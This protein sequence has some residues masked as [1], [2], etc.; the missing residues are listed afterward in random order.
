MYILGDR[1]QPLA[2]GANG[3]ASRTAAAPDA[4]IGEAGSDANA[5]VDGSPGTGRTPDPS[6]ATAYLMNPGHTGAGTDST[7]KPPLSRRWMVFL[8]APVSYPLVVNGFAYVTTQPAFQEVARLYKLDVSSGTT[9]WSV[10]LG[11]AS[12]EDLAFDR[13]RVF[14]IDGPSAN[15]LGGQ[16]QFRAFDAT[17]GGLVWSVSPLGQSFY[18][19]PPVAY[20]GIVYL[21]GTGAGATVYA[22]DEASGALLWTQ[23]VNGLD[24]PPAV[25]DDGVFTADG[26]EALDRISG[27]VVWSTKGTCRGGGNTPVVRWPGA[28]RSKRTRRSCERCTP[29]AAVRVTC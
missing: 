27:A 28:S 14:V 23:G 24:A 2:I 19:A 15:P 6:A 11:T 17:S 1:C 9:E 20:R 29:S 25:S 12:T 22:Y 4:S 18:P 5:G 21:Y 7:L 16:L 13:G 3:D 10:D 26:C 8:K